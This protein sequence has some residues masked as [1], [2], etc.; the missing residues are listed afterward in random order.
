METNDGCLASGAPGRIFTL[1]GIDLGKNQP[2]KK[3]AFILQGH[4]IL[5]NLYRVL[6]KKLKDYRGYVYVIVLEDFFFLL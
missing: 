6:L 3:K 5:K 2:K 4:F 1:G